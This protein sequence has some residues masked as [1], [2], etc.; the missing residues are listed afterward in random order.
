LSGPMP[1]VWLLTVPPD[2]LW[3][4]EIDR[5]RDGFPYTSVRISSVLTDNYPIRAAVDRLVTKPFS[6]FS[7]HENSATSMWNRKRTSPPRA[8]AMHCSVRGIS[9]SRTGRGVGCPHIYLESSSINQSSEATDPRQLAIAS[10]SAAS[11]SS[12]EE[13]L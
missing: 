6:Y 5:R 1:L 8:N 9:L 13:H 10:Q 11:R 4:N 12:R 7:F 2:R 3:K